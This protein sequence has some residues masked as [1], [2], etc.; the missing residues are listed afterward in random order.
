ML[1]NVAF[2]LNNYTRFQTDMLYI[3]TNE[4]LCC[5]FFLLISSTICTVRLGCKAD[6][7]T[8]LKPARMRS[9]VPKFILCTF[10]C[11]L[12][13]IVFHIHSFGN[14]ELLC[15]VFP[16]CPLLNS[17]MACV[18]GMSCHVPDKIH[19]VF[20]PLFF[21]SSLS[22]SVKSII[23]NFTHSLGVFSDSLWW[24]LRMISL[25]QSDQSLNA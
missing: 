7:T 4:I 16:L 17:V 20:T 5:V 8:E 13:H 10:L 9:N 21:F 3:T 23:D 22:V 12:A 1:S 18:P 25:H 15:C 11:R 19:V 24:T 6:T 14:W 2:Y